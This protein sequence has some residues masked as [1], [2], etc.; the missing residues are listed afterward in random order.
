MRGVEA[1]IADRAA[2]A[3]AEIRLKVSATKAW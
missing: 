2:D 3:R 1:R